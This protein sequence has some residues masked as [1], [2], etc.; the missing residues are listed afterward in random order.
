MVHAALRAEKNP[1]AAPLVGV[2]EEI[3]YVLRHFLLPV[4][5]VDRNFDQEF[6][7]FPPYLEEQQR[8]EFPVVVT[9]EGRLERG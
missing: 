9:F 7:V 1:A 6:P 4:L 5:V 3:E 2:L 8:L